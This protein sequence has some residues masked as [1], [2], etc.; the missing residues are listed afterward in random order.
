[1]EMWGERTPVVC[2]IVTNSP[3]SL[4]HRLEFAQ[5]YLVPVNDCEHRCTFLVIQFIN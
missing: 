5:I 3:G 2:V 4:K 1:M